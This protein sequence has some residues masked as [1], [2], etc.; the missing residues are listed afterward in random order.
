MTPVRATACSNI[1]LV[2]YW[3]KR[4]GVPAALNLPAVGSLSMTLDALRT[5]TELEPSPDPK[6]ADGFELDDRVVAGDEARKVFRHLDRVWSA[7]GRTDPRPAALVRSW[8]RFPT[9]AGLASSAS[10]F[11]ALTVAAARAFEAELPADVLSSLARQGSG[12]AARSIFGG[13]VRLDAGS[14]PDGSDCRARPIAGSEHWPL[15][16]LVVQ[17][18]AGR[19]PIGSTDGMERCRQTSPYYAAWVET[20]KA[21]LDAAEAAL[22]RRDLPALGRVVEHSC[23][24]M[25]AC[26]MATDPA[27]LYWNP[28]T[29]AVVQEVWRAREGGQPGF[30]TIDAG[31]HVKVLC[32][33]TVAPALAGR[34]R[35]VPGV[36]GVLVASPGPDATATESESRKA[37]A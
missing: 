12:S 27:L 36:L 35:A 34:L 32:E 16:L 6:Q 25:H 13:F 10:G 28:T 23:F 21:D 33:P 22:L 4:T 9:A 24:K 7:A 37:R 14:A 18:T 31:P 19:K 1:A 8:N 29:V 2:K 3:G 20:S 30:V 26:M 5:E 17:T 15:T 11:A